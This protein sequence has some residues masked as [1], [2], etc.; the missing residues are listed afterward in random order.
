MPGKA[1]TKRPGTPI[2]KVVV[3]AYTIPTDAPEA[4]GT[5]SWNST[6]LILAELHCGGTTGIGYSYGNHAVAILA[7]HL[8]DQC[9]VHAQALDIPKLHASM[10]RQVRNDGN[11]GIGAMAISALDIALWDLKAKLLGCS[12]VDLVGAAATS[13][14]AYGSGGFTSYSDKQLVKQLSGWVEDGIGSVKM[15][16]GTEPGRDPQRVRAARKAIGADAALFVDANGAYTAKQAI[17]L[18]ERFA[19]SGVTWF[20]EPVSSDH[21]D[22][23]RLVRELVPAGMDVAAGEYGYSP[24]YFRQML[25]SEAVDVL[26]LDATRCCGFTGFLT[27]AAIA[28][29][30]GCPLS[31]H[32]APSLHMHIA[33]AV[34][35]F[36][37][38]EYFHDHVRIEKMLF[39]GFIPA[40]DGQLEPDRSRPGLGLIFKHRD[41][42]RF[43]V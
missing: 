31:A 13:V 33:C 18:A 9:L 2:E 22:D 10:L 24:F 42:E 27:G 23:M 41:A 7:R 32:C 26:Q 4:D 25:S 19:E 11:I 37:N 12:V 5:L 17:A 16:I 38:V 43:A 15:K 34:P 8:A 20:E 39:D 40:R 36:R 30:F 29:S 14:A 35:G 28:S 6:T 1:L 3:S 21:L